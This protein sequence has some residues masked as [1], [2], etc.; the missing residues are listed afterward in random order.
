MAKSK[1]VKR[2]RRRR[3]R[4]SSSKSAPRSN[5]TGAI[6]E[7]A[8]FVV[9]GFGGFAATRLLTRGVATQVEQ[10]WAG[11]GKHAGAIASIASFAAA[12]FFAHRWK[13]IEKWS[14]PITVG[15]GIA[16]AQSLIQL[17]V[18]QL[19][20]VVSDA[21]PELAATSSATTTAPA[22]TSN[23]EDD[24]DIVDESQWYAYNDAR[25]PGPTYTRAREKNAQRTPAAENPAQ[26]AT[27]PSDD[28]NIFDI[29]EEE[30]L[31][32]QGWGAGMAQN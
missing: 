26:Q 4:G 3:A 15:A 30:E 13:A 22:A 10:R 12:F 2:Y 31:Q 14:M 8:E 1:L 27:Q 29:L 24:F 28:D 17:Y 23:S 9:P 32:S 6:G 16:A 21:T 18:P 19:G 5:P 11:W 7:V 20:W 25:D